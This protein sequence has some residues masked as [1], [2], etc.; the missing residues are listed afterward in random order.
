[1]LN[2]MMSCTLSV[3]HMNKMSFNETK[4]KKTIK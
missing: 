3:K 2:Q 1:M 4:K